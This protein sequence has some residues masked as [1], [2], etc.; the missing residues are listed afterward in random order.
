MSQQF[1]HYI[2]IFTDDSKS[3]LGVG[4]ALWIPSLPRHYSF[5]F[6]SFTSIFHAEQ[7]AIHQ[8]LLFIKENFTVGYF[9]IISDSLS[10][11]QS[12]TNS[13]INANSSLSL[14]I[15]ILVKSLFRVTVEF[16]WVP[17]HV[18]IT[19]NETVDRL[20]EEASI[21]GSPSNILHLSE[22]YP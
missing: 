20:A 17:S 8:T 1:S 4:A 13:P 19:H 3:D 22:I 21:S 9:L 7:V 18:G 12:I 11:L 14:L 5:S 16:L 10:A 6:P 15:I 2:Q